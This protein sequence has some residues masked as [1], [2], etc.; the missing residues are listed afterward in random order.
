MGIPTP[1]SSELDLTILVKNIDDYKPAFM[2]SEFKTEF[3]GKEIG[4]FVLFLF[5][6]NFQSLRV[7]H[8]EY[9]ASIVNTS[10]LVPRDSKGCY[11]LTQV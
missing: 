4:Q 5:L 2:Q 8:F 1:L 6:C 7:Y 11:T 10:L 3:T 9:R